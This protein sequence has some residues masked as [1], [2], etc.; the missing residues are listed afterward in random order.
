MELYLLQTKLDYS[1]SQKHII[2]AIIAQPEEF[3][4]RERIK[5]AADVMK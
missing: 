4:N 3:Q 2:L 5:R 1:Q